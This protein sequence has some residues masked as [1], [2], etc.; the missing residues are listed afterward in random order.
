MA[1]PG[2]ARSGDESEPATTESGS[3][4]W[5]VSWRP[6]PE[7]LRRFAHRSAQ[8][9][10]ASALCGVLTGFGVLLFERVT[11]AV[12]EWL[13]ALPLWLAALG[14]GIGLAVAY[15]GLRYLTPGST[16]STPATADEY[17]RNMH[18][19]EPLDLRTMPA[20]LFAAVATL[21]S[22]NAMG[23]E[24]PSIYLGSGLGT[25]LQRR[26]G[27]FLG[28]VEPKLL[29]TAGAAAGVAAIF[30]APFTGAV[31]ALEVPYRNDLGR[32][33]LLP[34][35]VGAATGYLA[36]VTV[37]GTAPLFPAEGIPAFDLR[38]LG[39]ALLLGVIGGLVA[40]LFSVLIRWAKRRQ[41]RSWWPRI[42]W[43][44]TTLAGLGL[45]SAWVTG[46]PL[47]L[48][49]G[50]EAI[51]WA[52]DPDVA[53]T[54][55]LAL[56]VLRTGATVASVAGGGAGGLFVPLVVIGAL[57][58]RFTGGV[59]SAIDTSLF[60]V[61]GVASVLGAGY[62]VPL[63]AVAFVAEATGQPGFIVPGLLAAVAADLVIGRESVTTYQRG[64][65]DTS[66]GV[67]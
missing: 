22:G 56:L 2:D 54:A 26:L 62:R 61:I 49:P 25:L 37:D 64:T 6:D 9:L 45:L 10:L 15:L 50:Y 28:T 7:R 51:A 39:G 38:D 12:L 67:P 1:A 46:E 3:P 14:P 35:L 60:T 5:D 53:L 43:W 8:V 30:K 57:V 44:G 47:A 42:V 65:D 58:G 20:R 40:R 36:F 34:A 16:R 18:E 21:G 31:F 24:G 23:F 17:I 13:L 63:A 27:R 48:G 52:N 11:I 19:V 32:H 66:P 4:W 41:S 29:M 59:L 33:L 55:V